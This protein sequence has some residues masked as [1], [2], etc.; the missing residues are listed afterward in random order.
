MCRQYIG[1]KMYCHYGGKNDEN[2][3]MVFDYY[4]R[5]NYIA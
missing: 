3:V 4:T 1:G 2:Y 5:F